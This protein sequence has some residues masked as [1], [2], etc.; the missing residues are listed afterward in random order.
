[1]AT[2]I[3]AHL[4]NVEVTFRGRGYVNNV[5]PRFVDHLIQIG[6]PP[7]DRESLGELLCHKHLPITNGNDLTVF[8]SAYLSGMCVSNFAASNDGD[9]NHSARSSGEPRNTALRLPLWKLLASNPIEFLISD[10]C[11]TFSSSQ[12]AIASD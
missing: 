1:V 4:S 2:L 12:C 5:R 11:T 3:Q 7:F 8:Y 6:E 9:L 10:C